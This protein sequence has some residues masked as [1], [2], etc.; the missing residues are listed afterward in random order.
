M[1]RNTFL[2]QSNLPLPLLS[3]A[4]TNGAGDDKK[5]AQTAN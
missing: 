1:L 3:L 5:A 2:S 4:D